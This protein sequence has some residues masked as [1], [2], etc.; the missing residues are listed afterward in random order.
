MYGNVNRL[1]LTPAL[2]GEMS[3]IP[4]RRVDIVEP[5]WNV[6]EET[7]VLRPHLELNSNSPVIQPVAYP[8]L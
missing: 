2:L 7:K 8:I 3:L 6:A 5:S 4:K 1:I